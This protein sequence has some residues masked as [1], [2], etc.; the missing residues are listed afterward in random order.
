MLL[1]K[2]WMS[3]LRDM[4]P[5]WPVVSSSAAALLHCI[6]MWACQ[7]GGQGVTEGVFV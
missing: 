6:G 2:E 3:R 4:I 5:D 7:G 1:V